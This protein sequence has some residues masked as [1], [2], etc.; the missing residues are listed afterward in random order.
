MAYIER[1]ASVLDRYRPVRIFLYTY[2]FILPFQ[3]FAGVRNTAFVLMLMLFV[4]EALRGRVS[5]FLR[6]RTVHAFGAVAAV[7]VLSSALSPYAAESFNFI[8]KNLLYQAA[9][10]IVITSEFDGIEDLRGVFYSLAAGFAGL[11][12]LIITLN[13]PRAVLDW[14]DNMHLEFMSGY[15]L[16]ATFFIPLVIGYIYTFE[17]RP[18]LKLLLSV[19]LLFWFA[20]SVLNNH[21]TQMISIVVSAVVMTLL[22]RRYKTLLFCSLLLTAAA[23]WI[24]ALKPGH[25]DRYRTLLSIETYTNDNDSGWN[26]RF[27]IWS[28]TLDIIR[29]RPVTGWGYGWKKIA[30]VVRDGEYLERWR[31]SKPSTYDYFSENGYGRAGPHNLALQVVFEVGLVG[32]L[33][34][35][36]FW[37]TILKKTLYSF[38]RRSGG[39]PAERFLRYTVPGVLL[40]Y[41]IINISNG[42]WEE[43]SGNLMASFA[44]MTVVAWREYDDGPSGREAVSLLRLYGSA[45]YHRKNTN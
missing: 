34:L 26:K 32:I 28:G 11:S 37:F 1:T 29:E 43:T 41:V 8:R 5:L 23:L 12:I 15:S 3:R 20:M 21:R 42:L 36:W 31:S 18:L 10:F 24:S 35:S 38:M 13:G 45:A 22:A 40:S 14:L 9:V 44:A 30:T 7:V 16:M 4:S 6:D 19:Q 33:A 25:F 2:L 39:G 17:K 27:A